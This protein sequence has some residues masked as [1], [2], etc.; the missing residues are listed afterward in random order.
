MTFINYDDF[1]FC[2]YQLPA[3]LPGTRP[4]GVGCLSFSSGAATT[5][6]GSPPVMARAAAAPS[7]NS[8]AA[9]PPAAAS[10]PRA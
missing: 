9:Q 3:P 10:R 1:P 8:E 2:F 7:A 6:P 5:V 4:A